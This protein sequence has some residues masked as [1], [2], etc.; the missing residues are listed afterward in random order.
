MIVQCHSNGD[1]GRLPWSRPE[2]LIFILTEKKYQMCVETRVG[3]T[4]CAA[5]SGLTLAGCT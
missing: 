5:P 4:Q 2:V 1:D 3:A